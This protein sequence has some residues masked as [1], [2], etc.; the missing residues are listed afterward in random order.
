ML[1]KKERQLIAEFGKKMLSGNLTKG[2]GGNL[3]IFNPE[4]RLLA[5][6]PGSMDYEKV[7][8]ED[9][10][11][12]NLEGA[13]IEGRCKPSSELEMHSVFYKGRRDILSLVHT[14]SVYATVISCLRWQ[15]P[16]V[17][18]LVGL[19]GKDVLCAPYS[20]FGSRELAENAFEYMGG[21][22]AVLL[23]NHGLLAGGKSIEE[24]FTTA[25]IIEFCAELYYKTKC[26][27][28]P[29]LL[30]EKQMEQAIERLGK[31]YK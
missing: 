10:A 21:R 2:T 13:K 5:I 25:E 7:E 23:A 3:S 24:A 1:L 4:Q 20:V 27:G 15:L 9:V 30:S 22:K 11:V 16:G 31:Y 14:H 26:A 17:H 29:V 8:P 18:Y 28:E 12:V 19:A 6:S